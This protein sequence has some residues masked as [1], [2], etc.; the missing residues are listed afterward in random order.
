MADEVRSMKWWGWG[1]EGTG[2]D[3]SNR[4]DLWP[5]IRS[6]L[7]LSADPACV[8]PVAFE[9]IVLPERK[10]NPTFLAELVERLGAARVRDDKQE[11]LTHAFGKSFRDLWRMRRGSVDY[12]PDAVVYPDSA[13]DVATVVDAAARHQVGVIPFG[14]GTN[15]AGCLEPLDKRNRMTVSVDMRRMNR[16]LKLDAE[17]ET[18]RFQAGVLG[19]HLEAQ[20]KRSGFTLGHFPDSFLYSTLG[21]WVA[22]RSAGMQSDRYGKIEDIVLSLK[23]VTPAGAIETLAVPRASSGI[24]V[25]RLCI[26]SE[27]TLG[28]I[29]EV[30]LNV[31]RVPQRKQTYGYLFPDF[32]SGVRALH[33]CHRE[34][35]VPAMARLND[36]NKTAL[37]FA[38]KTAQGAAKRGMGRLIK[39]YLKHIRRMKLEEACLMLVSHEGSEEAFER[40]RN[41]A[42]EIFHELGAF[43]LG[44]AP[45]KAFQ[46]GKFDFPYLRDFLWDRGILTDVSETATVWSNILPLYNAAIHSIEVALATH[47]RS[48][49]VGCH[50]SH[51]YHAGASLYFTFGLVPKPGDEF[52]QYLR[53]K[54]AAEDS[55]LDNGATLSHHHAVG[56]EHLPWLEREVSPAGMRAIQA[57]KSGLDPDGL[58]NSG[59]FKSGY[60]FADWGLPD[61]GDRLH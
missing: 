19:P 32:S 57:L 18:A 17:S 21:G 3:I 31:H 46:S 11:R 39:A 16:L 52:A 43:P 61:D 34:G 59:K 28:I 13:E 47:C 49:W 7:E 12:A 53:V 37:S 27:G 9:S 1:D 15:I 30:T 50:I 54:K 14:G 4:P 10:T 26:G 24:D 6:G 23:M 48:G 51:T 35:C 60:T 8:P 22:T 56:Y 42:G 2:F 33:R 45:G 5:Y 55:F 44:T 40:D 29:T 36:A 38:F 41:R 20:L 58:F 25:N